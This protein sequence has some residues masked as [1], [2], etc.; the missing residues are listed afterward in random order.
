M[1]NNAQY[2]MDFFGIR[3]MVDRTGLSE[4]LPID[5]NVPIPKDI[6]NISLMESISNRILELKADPR[7]KFLLWSGGI[8]STLVFYALIEANIDF[9]ILTNNNANLEYPMLFEQIESKVFPNVK[10]LLIMEVTNLQPST[11]SLYITGEIGDQISGSVLF[12]KYKTD[13]RYGCF[14][15]TIDQQ[16]IDMT[17]NS[18]VSVTKKE[19]MSTAEY[20]WALNFIFKYENVI[21]R[22]ALEVKEGVDFFHFYDSEDFQCW[23]IN[24]YENN[25][26]FN[27]WSEYKMPLKNIIYGYNKDKHYLN[28]KTKIESLKFSG[29]IQTN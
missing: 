29:I 9:T 12:K 13:E 21:N 27:K 24:N 18:V 8:D 22:I 23:A 14:R 2:F 25:V 5:F 7:N 26:I 19:N 6:R 15:E 16:I 10:E 17:F 3:D 1:E 20:L 28:N 11:E 4:T